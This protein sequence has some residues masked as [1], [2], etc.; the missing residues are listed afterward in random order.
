M[1]KLLACL[2]LTIGAHGHASDPQYAMLTKPE[3]ITIHNVSFTFPA[4][5][6]FP[7]VGWT[8]GGAKAILQIGDFQ[9]GAPWHDVAEAPADAASRYAYT[10]KVMIDDFNAQAKA[11]PVADQQAQQDV[12]RL[13]HAAKRP[14]QYNGQ[15]LPDN[16]IDPKQADANFFNQQLLNQLRAIQQQ[17]QRR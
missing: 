2:L 9:W 8:P 17:L 13:L 1:K 12:D 7:L 6:C 15:P 3:T 16:W 11:Q 14:T 5:Q 4:G 10:L